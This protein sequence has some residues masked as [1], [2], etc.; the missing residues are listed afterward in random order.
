MKTKNQTERQP[1]VATSAVF[2][3]SVNEISLSMRTANTIYKMGIT[4]IGE[5][6]QRTPKQW[7]QIKGVGKMQVNELESELRRLGTFLG[8]NA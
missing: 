4:T 6:A 5:I 7:L 3:R 2:A 8:A 1:Q